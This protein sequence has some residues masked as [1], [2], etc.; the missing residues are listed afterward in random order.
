LKGF[1]NFSEL[2]PDL[3]SALNSQVAATN[4]N[5]QT[6]RNE[7]AK[8]DKKGNLTVSTP[9]NDKIAHYPVT[10]LF[11][12]DRVAPVFEVLSTADKLSAVLFSRHQLR[13]K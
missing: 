8:I 12:K 7:Y 5:I 10:E 9:R 3:G 11:P 6:S 1:E 2:I 4:K 13:G